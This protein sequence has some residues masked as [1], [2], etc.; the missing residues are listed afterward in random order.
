MT[1]LPDKSVE[2]QI[3]LQ[4]QPTD[5]FYYK[6]NL[7]PSDISCNAPIVNNMAQCNPNNPNW[8]DISLNCYKQELCDNKKLASDTLV[9]QTTQLETETREKDM[10]Q[11]H[12]I[13]QNNTL[14]L[15]T[16]ILAMFVVM[17]ATK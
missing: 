7:M 13:S 15:M 3:T 11:V 1:S 2:N 5:F 14:N 10:N 12:H 4:F 9:S 8:V 17:Y 6:S 16:G